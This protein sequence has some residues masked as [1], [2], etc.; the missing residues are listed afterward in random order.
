MGWKKRRRPDKKPK[1]LPY[2]R[3]DFGEPGSRTLHL[4]HV[5]NMLSERSA[6]ELDPR[7]GVVAGNPCRPDSK[8][9]RRRSAPGAT[10]THS[11][12]TRLPAVA[13]SCSSSAPSLRQNLLCRAAARWRPDGQTGGKRGTGPCTA[14][15]ASTSVRRAKL[16]VAAEEH[17]RCHAASFS[18]ERQ[19][20]TAPFPKTARC[21]RVRAL[22]TALST[23]RSVHTN[24]CC[25]RSEKM[26]HRAVFRD[27]ELR[28][29]PEWQMSRHFDRHAG[30]LSPYSTDVSYAAE[31][32]S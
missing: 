12:L 29:R 4:S 17:G 31:A 5:V 1:D 25:I 18:D 7:F 6:D 27:A 14:A 23:D 16:L 26:A 20:Q 22:S 24:I 8:C 32:P 28:G 11:C 13:M 9:P 19:E 3:S 21:Y 15:G 10:R 2:T 30:L